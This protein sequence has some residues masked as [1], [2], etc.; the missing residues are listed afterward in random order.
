MII[1]FIGDIHGRACHA[2]AILVTWQSMRGKPFDLVVQLGDLGVMPHPETGEISY[3]RF[4]QWDPAV[5]DLCDIIM[6][7][8]ADARLAREIR[9]QLTSPILVVSGN[10]D[11]FTAIRNSID[12]KPSERVPL[13]PHDL[14]HCVPDGFTINIDGE[15]VGFFEGEA[16]KALQGHPKKFD[17]LVSHEGGFG[18]G[19]DAEGLQEGSKSLLEYLKT[20]KP[21][22]HV[23]GHFHHPVGPLTV[24]DTQCI[25]IASVVSNP[26][27]PTLQV[28]N[29]GC[30]GALNTETDDFEFVSGDWLST[31]QRKGGFQLLADTI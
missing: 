16:P 13:D 6:A 31:Y 1:G 29:A 8:G 14:F 10:H 24:H 27:D 11:E 5:Y 2:L 21:R 19:A 30:I 18:I 26:R 22:Y 3:D 25:Q 23:F 7:E 17:I 15:V 20:S 12:A 28:I 9:A 4:S